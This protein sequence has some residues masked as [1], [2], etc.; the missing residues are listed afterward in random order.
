MPL[1][2]RL[3]LTRQ[4]P[5]ALSEPAV[6]QGRIY[7]RSA[8]HLTCIGTRAGRKRMTVSVLMKTPPDRVTWLGAE[9]LRDL[10]L[11]IAKAASLDNLGL[12]A[13]E[14]GE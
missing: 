6:S 13:L 5:D 2:W 8:R 10:A 4:P 9:A 14:G 11:R 1:L 12:P 7:F 3:F